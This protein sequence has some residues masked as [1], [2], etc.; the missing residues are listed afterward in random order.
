MSNV[1]PAPKPSL[2][3]RAKSACRNANLRRSKSLM[4]TKIR[5]VINDVDSNDSDGADELD[6]NDDDDEDNLK[7]LPKLL[8]RDEGY[9]SSDN[10]Y[11]SN[12]ED[13]NEDDQDD[14]PPLED[15]GEEVPNEQD[16]DEDGTVPPSPLGRGHRKGTKTTSFVPEMRDKSYKM[17]NKYNPASYVKGG[18][19]E[20]VNDLGEVHLLYRGQKYVLKDGVVNVNLVEKIRSA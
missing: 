3:E 19:W 5:R 15:A 8:K 2:A 6:S 1:E 12:N 11:C 9:G 20:S 14:D 4:P 17:G 18:T 16:D 13:E 7:G 10:E